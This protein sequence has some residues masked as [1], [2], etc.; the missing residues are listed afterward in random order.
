MAVARHRRH[1]RIHAGREFAGQQARRGREPVNYSA[2]AEARH[3]SGG[4]RADASLRRARQDRAQKRL[5][6][7]QTWNGVPPGSMK[8]QLRILR[9][10]LRMTMPRET[11][12]LIYRAVAMGEFSRQI[13]QLRWPSDLRS[14]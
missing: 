3:R 5:N 1:E 8:M 2:A 6:R 13:L 9:L 14:E 4:G 10:R 11:M 7:G 12:R